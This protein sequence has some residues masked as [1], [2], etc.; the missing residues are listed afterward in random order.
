MALAVRIGVTLLA[1][2]GWERN[3]Y[4]PRRPTAQ[5]LDDEL[6][7]GGAVLASFGYA[8]LPSPAERSAAAEDTESRMHRLEQLVA[9]LSNKLYE[10]Q[11]EVQRE[12]HSDSGKRAGRHLRPAR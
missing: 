11:D 12:P 9:E 7:G 4:R 8:Q 2:S 5:R 6:R 3:L 1:V 10:V